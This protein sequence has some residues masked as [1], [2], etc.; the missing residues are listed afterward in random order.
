MLVSNGV[1]RLFSVA[2]AR[3]SLLASQRSGLVAAGS[4]IAEAS[5][6]PV[7]PGGAIRVAITGTVPASSAGDKAQLDLDGEDGGRISAPLR[8]EVAAKAIWGALCLLLGL[9]LLGLIK[10]LSREGDVEELARH[11]I[12]ERAAIQ[13]DWAIHPP[14]AGRLEMVARIDQDFDD[15]L[16]SLVKP[17]TLR[18]RPAYRR[19][20]R[21]FR[22][23]RT[24]PRTSCGKLQAR[25]L[26][27]SR[28]PTSKGSGKSSRA[29]RRRSRRHPQSPVPGQAAPAS[30]TGSTPY[31]FLGAPGGQDLAIMCGISSKGPGLGLS[32]GRRRLMSPGS[33]RM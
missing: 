32:L 27:R 19:C 21:L 10:F 18:H 3:I 7:P 28:Q 29:S 24:K 14:P 8:I 4:L 26:A 30:H 17:W 9:S 6:E 16:R 11:A 5:S 2:A 25:R 15:A 31:P 12:L 22:P 20:Q 13:A 23:R 1:E 33:S